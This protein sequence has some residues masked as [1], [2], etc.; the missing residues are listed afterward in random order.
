[1]SETPHIDKHLAAMLPEIACNTYQ[2]N[3]V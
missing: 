1:M 3:W 2:K